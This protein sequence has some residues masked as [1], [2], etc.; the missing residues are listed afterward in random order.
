MDIITS[1]LSF[2]LTAFILILGGLLLLAG[3][4]YTWILL[5]AGGFLITAA[6]IAELINN[7][8]TYTLVQDKVW[9]ALLIA[10][11]IGVLGVIIARNYTSIAYDII[12]FATGLYL[13]SWFDEIL[14]FLNG[15][16][17]NE[18]TWW[19]VLLF[20][21][22]GIVCVWI[23]RKD[24]EEAVIL[25]SVIIGARTITNG[26][27]LDNTNSFTAVIA[28]GLGLTGVVIQYASYLR[29]QPRLGRQLPPVPHPVSE[30]L[31]YK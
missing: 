2:V 28:L 12:G 8:D 18:I 25:I 19:L 15:Q 26:L 1:V 10:L 7:S 13:V 29:E 6:I 5:G 23:T 24:P 22:A 20:I 9:I 4:K 31:P 11:G 21:A 27:N 17:K 16:E 30:E 14:L 3:R